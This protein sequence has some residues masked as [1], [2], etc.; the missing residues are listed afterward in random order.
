MSS[1]KKGTASPL[2]EH[3]SSK[4]SDLTGYFF[5]KFDRILNKTNFVRKNKVAFGKT[6]RNP[7]VKGHE[8]RLAL[9]PCLLRR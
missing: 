8:N 2:V 7:F 1:Q 6:E 9:S 3:T 4:Y 5:R